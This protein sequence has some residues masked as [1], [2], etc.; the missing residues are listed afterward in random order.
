MY[1]TISFHGFFHKAIFFQS[2]S[3]NPIVNRL[4]FPYPFVKGCPG[5]YTEPYLAVQT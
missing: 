2:D 1:V 5:P 3:T 4:S